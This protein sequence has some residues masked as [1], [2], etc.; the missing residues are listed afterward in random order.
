MGDSVN[1][2]V[3]IYVTVDYGV[4]MLQ[5]KQYEDFRLYHRSQN[6]KLIIKTLPPF[7]RVFNVCVCVCGAW[8]IAILRKLHSVSHAHKI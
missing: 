3:N 6:L 4:F 8:M 2:Y 1:K 7:L 5:G